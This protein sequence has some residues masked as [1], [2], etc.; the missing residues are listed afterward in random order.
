MATTNITANIK[1]SDLDA[2]TPSQRKAA[3][4]KYRDLPM[5]IEVQ[6]A[7]IAAAQAKGS[8]LSDAERLEI[9][10]QFDHLLPA[11]QK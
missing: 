1:Q 4:E 5:T 8:P 11:N 6:Q 10:T 7:C 2:R 3:S 9:Y